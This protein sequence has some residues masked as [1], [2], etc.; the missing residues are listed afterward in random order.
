M[1]LVGGLALAEGGCDGRALSIGDGNG[2]GGAP[3]V[4][5]TS[6]AGGS[7]AGGNTYGVGGHGV[8]GAGIG[9]A[10]AGGRG[11]GGFGI[12]GRGTGGSYEMGGRGVGG[13]GVG[14]AI[15][16][17]DSLCVAGEMCTR[18]ICFGGTSRWTTLGG[19]VHHSGFNV[20]ER[21]GPPIALAWQVALA[22]SS[23]WPVVSDGATVYASAQTYFSPTTL[24][25]A[26][27]S[28]DG[29]TMWSYDFGNIFGV[30]Q[31]TVSGAR[32]YIAQCNNFMG[33]YMYSF[34]GYT[35]M[36]LWS[37]VLTAQWERYWAP[38]VA[39]NG[40]IYFDGG[41]YG[42]LYG[43]D[44]SGLQVFFNSALEQYDEW[45]PL[46][47]NGA[48]YTFVAGNLRSHDP[49]SGQ[50]LHTAAVTWNWSGW[51]MLTAPV[52]D[53]DKIYVIAPPSL[54]AFRPGAQTPSWTASAS[55][56]GMPAVAN[57]VVYAISG[58]QLRAT[59]AN[60]GT[61]LWTF[62][63]DSQLSYPPAIAGDYV[64]VASATT[65][66]AVKISTQVAAWKATPGG[67]LSIAAGQLYVAQPNG[68]LSAYTLAH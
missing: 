60:T 63:G 57:G 13:A 54:Y 53:G 19:D 14:G 34:T 4:A 66:Y 39:P 15:A 68:T 50:V 31:P 64:Y 29:H 26:L 62:V 67:W 6:G 18:G 35:S 61:V 2:E 3:G 17:C 37:A 11:A 65:A 27:S 30:G 28:T 42:G 10:G 40:R 5:G 21:G 7:G 51:S 8:G 32:V 36:L 47:L 48:L 22:Q 41:E 58:G 56:S 24:L 59:D 38:L 25:S 12:G 55:F 1:A 9:G 23:L 20:N 46:L 45:S 52:S 33:T 44:T 49:E 16:G 43:L